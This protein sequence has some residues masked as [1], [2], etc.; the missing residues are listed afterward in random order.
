M[1]ILDRYAEAIPHHGP[2]WGGLIHSW[3]CKDCAKI[4][5][6]ALLRFTIIRNLMA[7]ECV[8]C[9][10]ETLYERDDQQRGYVQASNP[11]K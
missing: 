11:S 10:L 9:I 8:F 5:F 1:F 7:A 2:F 6:E 3:R 4:S